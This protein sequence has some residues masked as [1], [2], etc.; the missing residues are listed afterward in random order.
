MGPTAEKALVFLVIGIPVAASSCNW[1]T[2][3]MG[4]YCSLMRVSPPSHYLPHTLFLPPYWLI[5][6]LVPS[7]LHF[8][9]SWASGFLGQLRKS[10]QAR[11]TYIKTYC[12]NPTIPLTVVDSRPPPIYF[13]PLRINQA[14]RT[15]CLSLNELL[16]NTTR[17]KLREPSKGA[18]SMPEAPLSFNVHLYPFRANAAS[19]L[20]G[21]LQRGRTEALLLTTTENHPLDLEFLYDNCESTT[22]L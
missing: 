4:V 13:M 21:R 9:R 15:F 1:S 22:H 17:M 7:P 5:A 18:S 20:Q 14:L 8:L 19:L 12:S 3:I 2:P 10:A 11:T 6:G 16:C